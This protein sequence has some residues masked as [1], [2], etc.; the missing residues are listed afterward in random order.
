MGRVWNWRRP[1]VFFDSFQQK[2]QM[3]PSVD[4]ELILGEVVPFEC[5]DQRLIW[6][7]PS[8]N[9][10]TDRSSKLS[11]LPMES[12]A[13]EDPSK[14]LQEK[15]AFDYHEANESP[16]RWK[17]RTHHPGL[18]KEQCNNDF[19]SMLNIFHTGCWVEADSQVIT[20]KASS[21]T[22]MIIID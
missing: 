5:S 4:G 18:S 14:T 17:N 21:I 20:V 13:E 16:Y 3:S 22:L 6:D 7:P 19:W 8:W 10:M 1:F 9:P 12:S 15:Y 2:L 11:D